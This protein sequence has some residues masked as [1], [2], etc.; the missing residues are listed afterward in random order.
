MGSAVG[1]YIDTHYGD[2]EEDLL[3]FFQDNNVKIC[4]E[5]DSPDEKSKCIFGL[6]FVN[7][8]KNML[9]TN[10]T[11]DIFNHK[12]FKNFINSLEIKYG[13]AIMP[14]LYKNDEKLLHFLGS[15]RILGVTK[16]QFLTNMSIYGILPSLMNLESDV[17]SD[18]ESDV[19][20][21]S[22]SDVDSDSDCGYG[23]LWKA[24]IY[25]ILSDVFSND[26]ES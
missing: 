21:N 13:I 6:V 20:S 15:F 10:K 12:N 18:S 3:S 19:N 2:L 22:E 1:I 26:A 11:Q 24:E 4:F 17:D 9:I 5:Y 7:N 16:Y 8:K 25:K 14:V 23:S